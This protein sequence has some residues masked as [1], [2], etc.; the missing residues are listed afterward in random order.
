LNTLTLSKPEQAQEKIDDAIR[1]ISQTIQALR[2]LSKN[3]HADTISKIGL[4]QSLETEVRMIEKLGMLQPVFRVYGQPVPIATDKSLIIF[5][6]V[7]EALHNVV[8][9]AQATLVEMHVHFSP[10]HIRLTIA[11]NG[12]GFDGAASNEKGSGIRNM[13]DRARVI[14]AEFNM[15]PAPANGTLITITIPHS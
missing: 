8:K 11:D 5:R 10:E 6:I 2:D 15:Q 1:L 12:K 7:Q 9:H 4:I 14:G 13:T 3:L